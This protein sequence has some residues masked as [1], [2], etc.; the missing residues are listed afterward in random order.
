MKIPQIMEPLFE[1]DDKRYLVLWGGRGSGKSWSVAQYLI[2]KALEEK[3]II[4]CTREHQISVKDSVH[5][6]LEETIS[7]LELNDYFII[8]DKEIRCKN[9][10]KFIFSGLQNIKNIKSKEA[11]KYVWI[12]EADNLNKVTFE[13]VDPTIR[14]DDSQIIMVFNLQLEDDYPYTNFVLKERADTLVINANYHDN[15]FLSKALI[16]QKDY[17]K[18]NDIEAYNHIWL[19]HAR[20]ISDAL[21]FKNK[22]VKEYFETPEDAIFYYGAD[23]GYN[24][25]PAVLVRSFIIDNTLYID[26]E[27]YGVKVELDGLP[28]FYDS[29]YDR[30]IGWMIIGDCHRPDTISF[31]QNQGF[32]IK[33]CK[34]GKGSVDDGVGHL[35]S[36]D[37]IVIH[38][39]CKYTFFEFCH[40]S[41]KVDPRTGKILPI[42]IDDH[43]HVIDS[44]RYSLEDVR[45]GQGEFSPIFASDSN[46]WDDKFFSKSG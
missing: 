6:L 10:S 46:N 19:G 2:L 9:N 34:K 41:Y 18:E 8:L 4:L 5:H 28:E 36:F 42:I 37:R 44:V 14:V 35:R 32:N 20:Q 31:L 30:D 23:F 38:P 21:I 16:S 12:E 33:G 43:N 29:I 25:D 22:F 24:P 1:S 13:T 27:A 11:I 40:Y 3:C 26:Q 7:R 17:A 39:R 45:R 15:P